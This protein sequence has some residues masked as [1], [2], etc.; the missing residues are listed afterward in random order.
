MIESEI[1]EFLDGYHKEKETEHISKLKFDEHT[2]AYW[3]KKATAEYRINPKVI[4]TK[5]QTEQGLIKGPSSVGPT[6][7]QLNSALNVGKYDTGVT[8]KGY[9]GFVKQI[10]SGAYT[11]RQRYDEAIL[12]DFTHTV[13]KNYHTAIT[14]CTNVFHYISH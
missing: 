14:I 13:Q 2:V 5:L 8:V 12:K 11:L 7:D 10:I 6:N 9:S 3:I 4:L 1:Q